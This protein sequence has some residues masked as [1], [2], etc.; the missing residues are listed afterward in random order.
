MGP[1]VVDG[2]FRR[3]SKVFFCYTYSGL[4]CKGYKIAHIIASNKCTLQQKYISKYEEI[5]NKL[6]SLVSDLV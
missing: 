6:Y 4:F 5:I 1:R 2:V 3:P